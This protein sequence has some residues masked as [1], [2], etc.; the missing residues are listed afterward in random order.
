MDNKRST[1]G[2]LKGKLM[3]SSRRLPSDSRIHTKALKGLKKLP[4]GYPL[5]SR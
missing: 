1:S 5:G 2:I 4:A 3:L